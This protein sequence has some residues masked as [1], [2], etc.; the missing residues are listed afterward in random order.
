MVDFNLTE[1]QQMLRDMAREFTRR[2][3]IPNAM[4]HDETGEFPVDIC[5]KAWE[6]GLLNLHIGEDYGG[7][8][9][10]VLE[11]AIVCEETGFGCSGIT[12]AMEANNLAE[13]P[14]IVAA[15]DDLKRRFLAPMTEEFKMAAYCVTEPGAGSDVSG[16]K[17]TAVK[18]GAKYILNGQ[19]MWITNAAKADYFVLAYTDPAAGRS[20]TGFVVPRETAGVIV[21]RKKSTWGNVRP[22]LAASPLKTS[23][24]RRTWSERKG[25]ASKSPWLRST[26]HGQPW[27]QLLSALHGVPWRRLSPTPKSVRRLVSLLRIFKQSRS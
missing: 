7:L 3:I 10:G 20:M 16:I 21:G 25:K 23:R 24:F 11:S 6:N 12:T 9:L 15:S 27:L 26:S 4:H 18:Q 22:I 2:E 5:R 19:K 17:T 14:L 1:E 13:S 8:G